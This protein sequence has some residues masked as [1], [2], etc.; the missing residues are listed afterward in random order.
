MRAKEVRLLRE[1]HMSENPARKHLVL[2]EEAEAVPAESEHSR[3]D[4][5]NIYVSKSKKETKLLREQHVIR[6]AT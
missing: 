4:I 6:R 3:A 2:S 5:H 1:Q